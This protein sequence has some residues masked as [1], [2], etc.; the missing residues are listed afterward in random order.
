MEALAPPPLSGDELMKTS[1]QV[2]HPKAALDPFFSTVHR[3]TQMSSPACMLTQSFMTH[4]P[5]VSRLGGGGDM[6]CRRQTRRV[7]ASGGCRRWPTI[8][9]D[10]LEH[11][12]ATGEA[13]RRAPSSDIR[14]PVAAGRD[15]DE[16]HDS[17]LIFNMS[18]SHDSDSPRRQGVMTLTLQHVGSHGES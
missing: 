13:R 6:H 8:G 1:L 15:P 3:V 9:Y 16:S 2:A 5:S 12:L 17:T 4:A 18:L 11:R 10:R 7:Y 14:L